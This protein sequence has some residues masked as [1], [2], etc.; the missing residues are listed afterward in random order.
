MNQPSREKIILSWILEV[1]FLILQLFTFFLFI[2]IPK[3]NKG[4]KGTILLITDLFTSPLLYL[5]IRYYFI[6]ENYNIYFFYCY[7]P[8]SSLTVQSQKL[9]QFLLKLPEK[10]I[11]I[12]GHGAGGL[13][14]LSISDEARKKIKRLITLD[15]P[16][17]GTQLFSKLSFIKAFKDMLPRSEF[18]ISYKM[19]ALLYEEFSPI[20]SWQDEWI[21]PENLLKF[22]QGRDIILDIPGRLN[23]ILH[24]ENIKTLIQFLNQLHSP[25]GILNQNN[26]NLNT[27][28]I[29]SKK[30]ESIAKKSKKKS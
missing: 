7:N 3:F 8:F 4:N 13:L 23:L 11:T 25:I 28:K 18:L 22:G 29:K 30:I 5:L 15:T 2:P 9:T 19:N 10:N 21:I 12:I 20:I 17:W 14:P 27:E 1:L 16:F 24:L 26:Q 6:K